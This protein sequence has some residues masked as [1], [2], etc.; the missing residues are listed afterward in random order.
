ME[1]YSEGT[2]STQNPK[3]LNQI[4]ERA[5]SFRLAMHSSNKDPASST[6]HYQRPGISATNT[7]SFE[8]GFFS[9]LSSKSNDTSLQIGAFKSGQTR[10]LGPASAATTESQTSSPTYCSE[11]VPPFHVPTRNNPED[12]DQISPKRS[13]STRDSIRQS[14]SEPSVRDL[15]RLQ[16]ALRSA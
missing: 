5:A 16:G 8:Q 3:Q 15:I 4:V 6:L 12:E 9:H 1:L 11:S 14:D 10:P 7:H 2:K 13:P